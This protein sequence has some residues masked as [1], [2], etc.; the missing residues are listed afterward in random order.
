MLEGFAN[1]GPS[2]AR[3]W[4]NDTDEKGGGFPHAAAR[5]LRVGE[6]REI[7]PPQQPSA[8]HSKIEARKQTDRAP[9]E[10]PRTVEFNDLKYSVELASITKFL[11]TW[12]SIPRAFSLPW[13][14]AIQ[15]GCQAKPAPAA[16][17][18]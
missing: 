17:E 10:V 12:Y 11:R 5:E 6:E 9:S 14:E 4:A 8:T 3:S 1:S 16:D 18:M 7:S 13:E 2:S 15:G